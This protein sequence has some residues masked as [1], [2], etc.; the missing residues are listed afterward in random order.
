MDYMAPQKNQNAPPQGPVR[1]AFLGGPRCGKT[2][3]ISKL[4]TGTYRETYYP[5][6]KTI[7]VLF[8]YL[9]SLLELRLP[10]E[11]VSAKKMLELA[12]T[13]PNVVLSPVIYNS[14]VH[15]A[16]KD[17]AVQ[18]KER[19]AQRR[20]SHDLGV[21]ILMELIDTPAFN[22]DQFV[23]FLEA[24]LHAK[25]AK[26]VLRN[27][28]DLPRQPVNTEPLLVASG[29]GELNGAVDGYFLLYSAVP[30][31]E[32]PGY[33]DHAPAS[34]D[35]I[36][37]ASSVESAVSYEEDGRVR[38][39]TLAS[40]TMRTSFSLL[41]SMK[42]AL[43]EAWKEFYTWKSNWLRGMET[44]MFSLKSAF[45]GMFTGERLRQ[46]FTKGKLMDTSLDPADP[47]CSPPIWIVCTHV[48][49]HLA[50]PKLI[51]EGKKLAKLWRCGF[52]ALDV[53]EDVDQMLSLMVR[54]LRER[55]ILQKQRRK[56]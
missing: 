7:P 53:Q 45:K 1:L 22:P 5:L 32:P 25:L 16:A 54:E 17:S 46:E 37:P 20:L 23:P 50:S 35:G 55:S 30:L 34:N 21:P 4:T 36:S 40:S 41:P 24:S 2:A 51:S 43:D 29:A 47:S 3:L 49:L 26:D 48:D 8:E 28:A 10:L 52:I 56:R 19:A 9:P 12:A 27:L 6:R 18:T 14:L 39:V 31:T 15:A 13:Q 33:F 42:A 11:S 44:D 38:S